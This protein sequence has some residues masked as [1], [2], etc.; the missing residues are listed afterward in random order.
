MVSTRRFVFALTEEG[1]G[2]APSWGMP[3]S[4]V[5]Y[6]VEC[7]AAIDPQEDCIESNILLLVGNM[8]TTSALVPQPGTHSNFYVDI[9]KYPSDFLAS[10]TSSP[11]GRFCWI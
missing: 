2:F 1:G 11:D 9:A 5:H 3:K 7:L 6:H 4:I 10:G 8:T